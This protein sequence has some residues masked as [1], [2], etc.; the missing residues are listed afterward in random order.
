[1]QMR[2]NMRKV[3]VVVMKTGLTTVTTM[4]TEDEE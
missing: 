2:L 1:M 4:M 3:V